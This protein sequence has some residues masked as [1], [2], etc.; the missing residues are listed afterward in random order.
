MVRNLL[1]FMAL[2]LVC[3]GCPGSDTSPGD[4]GTE[5]DTPD[6]ATADTQAD[7][8]TTDAADNTTSDTAEVTPD[9]E[10]DAGTLQPFV[11]STA[12]NL[13]A[14]PPSDTSV[15]LTNAFPNLNVSFPLLLT[16]ANDGSGRLFV[17][18]RFGTIAV[19]NN[20][21]EVSTRA[22][23]LDL[24]NVIATDS[25]GGLLGLDFHPDYANNGHFF[26]NYTIKI[27]S[28]MHT[29]VSRFTVSES[30]PNQ[31]NPSSE[32]VLLDIAQPFYNHN[33]GMIEFGPD[34]YLYIGMG[35]GGWGGD[36]Y[37]HGQNT[38]TLHG[39]MLRI[40]VD[41]PAGGLNYGIPADNPFA[42]GGGRAEIFAWGLRNPWRFSFDTLTGALWS[43]DVGQ[44]H[45]EEIAVIGLG[46]NHGWNAM[47][48]MACFPPELASCDQSGLTLPIMQYPTNG[49]GS[50]TGGYVYR[51]S[52][53]PSL[54]GTYIFAD[55]EQ[56]S[57]YLLPT[58][59]SPPEGPALTTPVKIA[60]FGQDA[61]G[62]VYVL[63]L[64]NGTIYRFEE[65]GDSSPGEQPAPFPQTLAETGCFTDLATMEPAAGV[66]PYELNLPFWSDGAEKFRW[67]VLPDGGQIGFDPTGTWSIPEGTLFIKHFEIE[68]A[69]DNP[70]SPT[71]LETRF[72]V[73]EA[74]GV[75]GYVYRW[76]EAGT[77]A[78]LLQS[79][80]TREVVVTEAGAPTPFTWQFPARHQCKSCHT[81]EAGGILGLETAQLNRETSLYGPVD[82][83]LTT[84]TTWDLFSE[85][86]APTSL[87]GLPAHAQPGETGSLDDRARSWLHVNCAS[88]HMGVGGP[89]DMD[90]RWSTALSDSATCEVSPNKGNLGIDGAT[91]L[92]AGSPA[93]SMIYQRILA[94]PPYRMPPLATS[95]HD[96]EA[97]S[98]IEDWIAN[99]SSCP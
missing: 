62:E 10:P 94:Q 22:T 77:E 97:K 34:G 6:T 56:Y 33:G 16:H 4:V 39:A 75:R 27:G 59:Q 18:E 55:Y 3:V 53:V 72:L 63:G 79:G 70:T 44:N 43:G 29:I 15:V 46:E 88:C 93:T 86:S 69:G 54:Y 66:L 17:L 80:A 61:E 52:K 95:R 65:V 8:T 36:P 64:L 12:C 42:Q 57:L 7:N 58:D 47:E 1:F 19:F 2:S 81:P 51:G 45:W 91:L 84:W 68:Q 24:S 78:T 21:P 23:F 60:G 26:V 20:D 99:L 14:E 5:T 40:D 89:E 49:K 30:N 92:S 83:Q 82:N 67:M 11:Y 85:G 13:P 48:G 71:R 37:G 87:A 31:A 73:H 9:V 74:D 32:V 96:P 50:V 35:D 25:E 90:L 41:N 38:D 98:L 28:T 76:N